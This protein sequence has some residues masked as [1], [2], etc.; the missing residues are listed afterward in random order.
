VRAAG[1]GSE[2]I[3]SQSKQ[4]NR[5][6]RRRWAAQLATALSGRSR[7][8]SNSVFAAASIL[9]WVLAFFE[10]PHDYSRVVGYSEV[11]LEGS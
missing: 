11:N 7:R 4:L 1:L 10:P 9:D 5:V 6:G 8:S 2:V 3:Y